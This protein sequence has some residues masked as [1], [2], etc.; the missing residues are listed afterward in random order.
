[1]LLSSDL[2]SRGNLFNHVDDVAY[3][4]GPSQAPR[5]TRLAFDFPGLVEEG[6]NFAGEALGRELRFW[7]HA[8]C[9]GALHL[10]GIAQLVAVGGVP[11]WDEDGGASGSG[12]F[13]RGNGPGA[14]N[15]Y[16]RPGE[17]LSHVD[18]KG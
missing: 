6:G 2:Y 14:A 13:R 7:N 3:G 17:A 15:N 9:A 11:K 10:L 18:E 5:G 12:N 8:A 4:I 16:V 1:M